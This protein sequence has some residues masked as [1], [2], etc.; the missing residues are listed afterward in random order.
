MTD[1]EKI[2]EI[3]KDLTDED[4]SEKGDTNLKQAC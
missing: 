3:L 1:A 2:Y 4:L